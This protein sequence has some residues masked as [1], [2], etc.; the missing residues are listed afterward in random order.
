MFYVIAWMI[1]VMVILGMC[2]TIYYT[3]ARLLDL[4]AMKIHCRPMVAIHIPS[5]PCLLGVY[6]M[7]KFL[8]AMMKIRIS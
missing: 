2:P 5:L 6:G 1:K 7:M 4:G 8:L 3:L